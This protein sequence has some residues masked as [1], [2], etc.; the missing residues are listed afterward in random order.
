MDS[1]DIKKIKSYLMTGISYMIPICII[2]GMFFAISIGFGADFTVDSGVVMKSQFWMDVQS[3]GIAGLFMMV[4]VVGTY[5]AYAIAGKPAMAP[6]FVLCYLANTEVGASGVKTGFLGAMLLGIATGILVSYL[7]K[8]K[9]PEAVK[10]IVPIIIIPLITVLILGLLYIEVLV[11]PI[12]WAIGGMTGMLESMSDTS[13]VIV[14]MLIGVFLAVDMGGPINKTCTLFLYMMAESGRYE[15][16]AFLAAGACIPAIGMG[17]ATLMSKKRYNEQERIA[18]KTSLIMGCMG[19]TEGAIPLAVL[20]PIRVIPSICVGG[21]VG[22]ALVFYFGVINYC[23]HGGLIVLPA[24]VGQPGYLVSV[25]VGSLV[26]AVM[27]NLL[28]KPIKIETEAEVEA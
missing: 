4:P 12:S 3:I 8:V 11:G 10:P 23:P 25:L 2:G 22:N 18:G 9:W 21:A 27:V 5:I 20:D 28:K 13:M 7:K 17:L 6:A 19:L 14:A 26:T 24:I 16:F 1:F 15:F